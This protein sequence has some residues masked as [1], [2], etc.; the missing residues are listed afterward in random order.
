[1]KTGFYD[2]MKYNY[3]VE[4]ISLI[5]LALTRY[6]NEVQSTKR[7]MRQRLNS[8]PAPV[9]E[10]RRLED[11]EQQARPLHEYYTV[12]E[13]MDYQGNVVVSLALR[14]VAVSDAARFVNNPATVLL[15][16]EH[17]HYTID[18]EDIECIIKERDT[19]EE[20][21][22]LHAER[23]A[24]IEKC[25]LSA[26]NMKAIARR[27]MN[28]ALNSFPVAKKFGPDAEILTVTYSTDLE[29]DTVGLHMWI[30]YGQEQLNYVCHAT[31]D[32]TFCW[33]TL[34]EGIRENEIRAIELTQ[35]AYGEQTAH[36][37]STLEDEE[38][39]ERRR[40][41]QNNVGEAVRNVRI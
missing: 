1:M 28:A 29:A 15:P 37:T 38:R 5:R 8:E 32:K 16:A 40:T 7:S 19:C 35:I 17:S 20:E 18:G 10:L 33:E 39:E 26:W 4:D 11:A 6:E 2:A 13:R 14:H 27:R 36:Q 3:L 22:I 41:A 23:Q 30:Q 12:S 21:G 34:L 9:A 25:Y 31:R 24:R